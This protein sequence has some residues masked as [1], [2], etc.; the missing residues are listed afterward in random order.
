[1]KKIII[2]ILSLFCTE[3]LYSQVEIGVNGFG[4]FGTIS[5]NRQPRRYVDHFYNKMKLGYM[6]GVYVKMNIFGKSSIETGLLYNKINCLWELNIYD[7]AYEGATTYA[8]KNNRKQEYI[9]IPLLYQYNFKKI[10]IGLGLQ[11]SILL[12][13]KGED[14]RF[15]FQKDTL[16]QND[17]HD[18]KD[19]DLSGVLQISYKLN[20]FIAIE[21]RY[22]Q[23][24]INTCLQDYKTYSRQFML[25]I[26]L[27]LFRKED[28]KLF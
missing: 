13:N 21:A 17:Y 24:I 2:V 18:L 20:K 10:S 9:S 28:F 3:I 22:N 15:S 26:K 19:Y 14:Y 11:Y 6:T 12:S 4:G 25:G 1:M 23:G 8:L 27:S 7:E 16:I 5:D